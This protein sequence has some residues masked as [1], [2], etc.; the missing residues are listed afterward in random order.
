MAKPIERALAQGAGLHL[1]SV[2]VAHPQPPGLQRTA[3]IALGALETSQQSPTDFFDAP[4]RGAPAPG[5]RVALAGLIGARGEELNG[6]VGT[7]LPAA[8][9]AASLAEGRVSVL[10]NEEERPVAVRVQNLRVA[11]PEA[12]VEAAARARRRQERSMRDLFK[13]TS[14]ATAAAA[15]QS[16]AF[17]AIAAVAEE[18]REAGMARARAKHGLSLDTSVCLACGSGEAGAEGAAAAAGGEGLPDR[19]R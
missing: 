6:K 2:I 19:R 18:A 15:D 12:A 11:R 10:L 1:R 7:V 3:R 16:E 13:A 8:S 4:P 9:A 5:A 14:N 17:A